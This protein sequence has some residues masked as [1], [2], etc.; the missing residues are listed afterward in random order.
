M[1]LLFNVKITQTGLL[2]RYD[3]ADWLPKYNRL[4]I[5]KYSLSSYASMLPVLTKCIFYIELAPEF[6]HQRPELEAYIYK[7]F[8]QH[9]VILKWHRNNYTRDWRQ[10]CEEF[11]TEDDNDI[12]WYAGN[13]D[14]IFIDYN[15]DM[16]YAG[17]DT[18]TADPNPNAIVYYSHWPEQM[19]L[20]AQPHWRSEVTAD[21]NFIKY[22]WKTMDSIHMLKVSR[23]RRYWFE[24]DFGDEV[25]FRTDCFYRAG[26]EFESE[27]AVYAPTREMAR[28]YDGY[29]HVGD[30]ANVIAPLYIPPGFFHNDIKIRVGFDIRDNSYV[31]INPMSTHLYAVT[32]TGTDHRWV[33][34]DI[35][36]F[37]LDKI[38]EMLISTEYDITLMNSSRDLYYIKSSRL[39]MYE[40]ASINYNYPDVIPE[41]V[42]VNHLRNNKKFR[43]L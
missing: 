2:A 16:V 25:V 32:E 5:F 29:S 9:L 17:I 22:N 35:P 31:N 3:R 13:D 1:I 21:K 23:F 33:I 42:F 10:M 36:L 30:L 11:I 28:H 20:C 14:H 37:W 27:G 7:L 43:C 19:R 40:Y 15:L 24:K 6:T 12:I 4:D 26:F 8:P 34:E 41:D 18:L 39:Q 38:T